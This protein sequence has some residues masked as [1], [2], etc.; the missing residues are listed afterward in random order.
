M[1]GRLTADKYLEIIKERVSNKRKPLFSKAIF[2]QD[3]APC[4]SA[5]IVKEY[6][7]ETKIQLLEWPSKSPDLNVIEQV[8]SFVK[9][10]LY[11]KRNKIN[12]TEDVW[13]YSQKTFFSK[14]CKDL[15]NTLYVTYQNRIDEVLSQEGYHTNY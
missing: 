14:K 4:H 2:Q 1:E 3:N 11:K 9:D 10:K 13:K 7:Q 6:F 12:S 15:I 8:W 5:K